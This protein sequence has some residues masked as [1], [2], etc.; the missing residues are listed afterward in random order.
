MVPGLGNRRGDR[1][2]AAVDPEHENWG[3]HRVKGPAQA[4]MPL[5]ADA[6]EV[7]KKRRSTAVE[8]FESKR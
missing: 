4:E 7:A 8:R 1:A 6:Q 5:H 3:G 2:D